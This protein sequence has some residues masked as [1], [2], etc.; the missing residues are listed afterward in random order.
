MP[1]RNRHGPDYPDEESAK[2]SDMESV[3]WFADHAA[4]IFDTARTALESGQP[5]GE[6]TIIVG[7]EGGIR[8]IT[9]SDWSLDSLA[10][11]H[12]SASIYRVTQQKGSV[13]LEGRSGARTC[14]FEADTAPMRPLLQ[15]DPRYEIVEAQEPIR[16]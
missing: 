7:R 9:E 6:L 8:V 13:R 11:E 12:G 5:P 16:A 2:P 3:D 10:A 1:I 15:D 14:I 4:S